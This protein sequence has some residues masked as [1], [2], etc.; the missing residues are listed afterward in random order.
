LSFVCTPARR[1][2]RQ[3]MRQRRVRALQILVLTIG[4]HICMLAPAA[5]RATDKQEDDSAFD[6]FK[7]GMHRAEE[8]GNSH[9]ENS[10]SGHACTPT[11]G[12]DSATTQCQPWCKADGAHAAHC[13]VLKN[14]KRCPLAHTFSERYRLSHSNRPPRLSDVQVQGLQHLR[15][16]PHTIGLLAATAATAH[17]AATTTTAIAVLLKRGRRLGV[18]PVR[19]LVLIRALQFPLYALQM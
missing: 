17:K 14:T 13:K 4:L 15:W 10:G 3:G 18:F 8:P 12:S 19:R 2:Q 9:K 7:S 5:A 1:H 11:A 6:N 16:R